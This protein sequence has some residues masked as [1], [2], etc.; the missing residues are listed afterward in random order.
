MLLARNYRQSNAA[1]T[2]GRRR[3][4]LAEPPPN[5]REIVVC[6]DLLTDSRWVSFIDLVRSE[7]NAACC[8]QNRS[9]PPSGDYMEPSATY[10]PTL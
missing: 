1:T 7:N 9:F 3:W 2:I 5:L 8:Q 6:E 10:V 4:V